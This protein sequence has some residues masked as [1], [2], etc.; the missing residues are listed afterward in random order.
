MC[1]QKNHLSSESTFSKNAFRNTI[2]VSNRLDPDQ[3][4]HIVGP[5]L[6]TICL[7]KLSA[8]NIEPLSSCTTSGA[9][10]DR[11]GAGLSLTGVTALCPWARHINPSLA[12]VQPRKTFHY[13]T[14]RLM[15][16]IKNKIKQTKEQADLCSWF[17]HL[18]SKT[19]LKWPLKKD[20]K[21]VSKTDYCLMQVK[22]QCRMPQESILQYFQP[23]LSYHFPLGPL[24]SGCFSQVLLYMNLAW[25]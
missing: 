24:F 18:Y 14:E 8:N 12:L 25:R 15:M 11:G 5:D 1:T 10:W 22:K 23:S 19:C 2:W 9:G 21:L 4:R 6:G 20:D 17:V 13:I 3:A 16:D 7:Q